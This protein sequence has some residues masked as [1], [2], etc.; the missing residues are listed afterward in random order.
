MGTI[1]QTS[2]FQEKL[3][4]ESPGIYTEVGVLPILLILLGTLFWEP[5]LQTNWTGLA[6]QN[7][8]N[9]RT[10]VKVHDRAEL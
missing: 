3:L 5:E 4:R 1:L 9:E 2:V 7:T 10:I 8:G 6:L